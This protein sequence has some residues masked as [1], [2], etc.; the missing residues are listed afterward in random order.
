[1]CCRDNRSASA[2]EKII[3]RIDMPIGVRQIE[4]RLG[5]GCGD[6]FGDV[7]A[8]MRH[9]DQQRRGTCIEVVIIHGL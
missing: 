1:M 2:I 9:A 4:R 3:K 5:H 7:T 6:F 8:D